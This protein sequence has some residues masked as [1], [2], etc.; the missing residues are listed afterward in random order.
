MPPASEA[1]PASKQHDSSP[2]S[3]PQVSGSY[4]QRQQ[5]QRLH[6]SPLRH[7]P[8]ATSANGTNSNALGAETAVQ[9]RTKGKASE[10]G[11]PATLSVAEYFRAH[12]H[13]YGRAR[14][15]SIAASMSSPPKDGSEMEVDYETDTSAQREEGEMSDP[16]ALGSHEPF[17]PP[18]SVASTTSPATVT[19]ITVT[20]ERSPL[21]TPN[22]FPERTLADYGGRALRDAPPLSFS[23]EDAPMGSRVV[24]NDLDDAQERQLASQASHALSRPQAAPVRFPNRRDYGFGSQDPAGLARTHAKASNLSSYLAGPQATT[25]DQIAQRDA[26]RER[27]LTMQDI[28]AVEYR[29]RI[30][31]QLARRPVPNMR[32]CPRVLHPGESSDDDE[33]HFMRWVEKARKLPSLEALMASYTEVDARVE[34]ALR[35][36][37]AKLKAKRKL[38]Y[39]YRTMYASATPVAPATTSTESVSTSA[40]Q[41]R[42]S[43]ANPAAPPP[44]VKRGSTA[45]AATG[46]RPDGRDQKRPRRQGNL[47]GGAPRTP[48]SS[49]SV[50]NPSTLQDTGFD[51]GDD[52]AL[53]DDPHESG[54]RPARRATPAAADSHAS[55]EFVTRS[56]F[57]SLTRRLNRHSERFREILE[58]LDRYDNDIRELHERVDWVET[59][60]DVPRRLRA[61]EFGLAELRGSV[62]VLTGLQRPAAPAPQPLAVPSAASAA[63]PLAAPPLASASAPIEANVSSMLAEPAH[64]S[65]PAPGPGKA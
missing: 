53:K 18:Y 13:I 50:D 11:A 23:D 46:P 16:D 29:Q 39:G 2:S 10:P 28:P 4:D 62:G 35:F 55:P 33:V 15:S 60:V 48:T 54:D 38:S 56:E 5:P 25:A 63:Q 30:D 42:S 24:T 51:P 6:A 26:L 14:A 43:A 22:P 64:S 41:S 8:L 37:F 52:V 9:D 44:N 7:C 36:A 32:T 61:L 34:R 57:S 27:F 17:S 45:A 59:P 58:T 12:D 49:A 19:T 31:D 1:S 65:S 40:G 20:S 3:D 47:A 21:R